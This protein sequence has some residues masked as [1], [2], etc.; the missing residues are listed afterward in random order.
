[1]EKYKAP[2]GYILIKDPII[3]EQER[4]KKLRE[5]LEE[6]VAN[7]QEPSDEELIEVG[8]AHHPYYEDLRLL[9]EL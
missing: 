1:M 4:R 2:T 3:V 6:R 8:K 7:T 5:E 9:E